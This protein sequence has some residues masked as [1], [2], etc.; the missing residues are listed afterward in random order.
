[1]RSASPGFIERHK[2]IHIVRAD[3]PAER[4]ARQ[5]F[6]NLPRAC[7]LASGLGI[8]DKD[9]CA[10]RSLRHTRRVI[11]PDDF[12]T[13]GKTRHA[14]VAGAKPES[15][16]AAES[17]GDILV[18]LHVGTI[19]EG[20]NHIAHAG[21][22]PHGNFRK[23]RHDLLAACGSLSIRKSLVRGST[24]RLPDHDLAVDHDDQRAFV[25]QCGGVE[26]QGK[27]EDVDA[28][29]PVGGEIV[30]EP[31]APARTRRQRQFAFLTG[32]EAVFHVGDRRVG[33][34]DREFRDV[35]SGDDVLIQ[36]SRRY[37]QNG[38]DIVKTSDLN[39]LR[40]YVLFVHIH[41]DQS[42]HR[43]G[44]LGSIQALDRHITC[45]KPFG[46]RVETVFHP[47]HE[48]IDIF[49][50]RLRIARRRHQTSA[51]L[52]QRL[53]PDLRVLCRSLEVEG[54]QGEPTD[55]YA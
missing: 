31:H 2:A 10:A 24:N 48:R 46:V 22:N 52:A 20:H 35:P 38:R 41:T 53:F 26:P 25:F 39:V 54:V 1:M 29:L 32:R 40:E 23:A 12:D 4:A 55:L 3:R 43:S 5:V 47:S 45:F 42:L 30:L 7:G 33:T 34:A 6:G 19:D 49:L 44:V 13:V 51:Q 37:I 14:A 28:I 18:G 9:H 50:W 27:I 17:G 21:F 16:N 11:G 36:E 8:A 15:S